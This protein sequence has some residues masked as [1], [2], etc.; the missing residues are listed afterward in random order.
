VLRN[1]RC[2]ALA[3]KRTAL[4]VV[5]EV[6]GG[7]L[8]TTPDRHQASRS[9]PGLADEY[10]R[11]SKGGRAR[12][13]HGT[14]MA[15]CNSA[16]K[17]DSVALREGKIPPSYAVRVLT[18]ENESAG[19]HHVQPSQGRR[20]SCSKAR[21]FSNEF[22]PVPPILHCAHAPQG[23]PKGI[24]LIA[25]VGMPAAFAA[26]FILSGR[27]RSSVGPRG[28]D[29]K[30]SAGQSRPQV[31]IAAPGVGSPTGRQAAA[32]ANVR[33]SIAARSASCVAALLW[34]QAGQSAATCG[35]YG[36]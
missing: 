13:M 8:D 1:S 36:R 34:R 7:G 12:T 33:Y 26:Q 32:I 28:A 16:R 10:D 20:W 2:K 24:V 3:R 27:P 21:A 14:G 23:I 22:L 35:V 18:A 11:E 25:P 30:L 15:G 5:D 4:S 6:A 31:A 19:K 17:C 9:Q 29:D